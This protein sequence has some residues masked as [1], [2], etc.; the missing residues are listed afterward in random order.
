MVRAT[1]KNLRRRTRKLLQEPAPRS[2]GC[3]VA[4][5]LTGLDTN[6]GNKFPLGG[7]WKALRKLL[8][9]PGFFAFRQKA[10]KQGDGL[11]A[12][13]SINKRPLQLTELGARATQVTRNGVISEM[14]YRTAPRMM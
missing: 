3:E 10:R 14:L 5:V 4:R 12:P 7:I 2:Q 9:E 6:I 13:T 8:L 11:T 1:A